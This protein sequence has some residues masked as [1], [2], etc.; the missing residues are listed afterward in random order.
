VVARACLIENGRV[1]MGGTAAELKANPDIQA[2]YL[3][4]AGTKDYTQVKH[5]RRRKRWLSQR[6]G[7]TPTS[8]SRGA[9]R[10]RTGPSLRPI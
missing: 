6:G 8:P 9:E 4:G 3:G 2:F 1:V 7:C 5:Y 10:V